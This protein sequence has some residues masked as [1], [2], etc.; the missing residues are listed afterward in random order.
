MLIEDVKNITIIKNYDYYTAIKIFDYKIDC[1]EAKKMKQKLVPAWLQI[2][3]EN[4]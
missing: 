2:I 3:K 1:K 4:K